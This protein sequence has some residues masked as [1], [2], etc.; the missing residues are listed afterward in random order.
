MNRNVSSQHP[1]R[2]WRGTKNGARGPQTVCWVDVAKRL[3]FSN[4]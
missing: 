2:G 4:A 1:R 3:L